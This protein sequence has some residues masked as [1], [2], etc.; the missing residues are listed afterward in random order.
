MDKLHYYIP[1]FNIL[2][3]NEVNFRSTGV[4][5]EKCQHNNQVINLN[6]P[7]FLDT[8]LLVIRPTEIYVYFL[9]GYSH[10][11]FSTPT[12]PK[13]LIVLV[14]MRS[15]LLDPFSHSYKITLNTRTGT[16]GYISLFLMIY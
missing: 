11:G 2:Y 7:P 4:Y 1:Y 16:T 14:L 9:N 6:K 12:V 8:D 15:F 13:Q 5:Y 10:Q 3:H